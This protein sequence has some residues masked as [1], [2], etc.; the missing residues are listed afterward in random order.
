MTMKKT[1]LVFGLLS[2][3]LSALL[4][5]LTVPFMDRIG[6]DRGLVVGYTAMV[7]SFLFVYFGI[8][9]Y[10]DTVAGGQLSF[11][12]GVAVGLLITVVSC[13]CYVVAWQVL[14]YNFIPDFF[15]KYTAHAIEQLRASGASPAAIDQ[16]A[17]EMAD[18]KTMY[19]NPLVNA[20]FTFIEP[21]PVGLAITL[22]SAGLLRRT[23]ATAP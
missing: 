11:G 5:V 16:K 7:V 9:S 17:R 4:M 15:D 21:F 22:I 12:R 23:S 10:R 2:G 1:V 6:F 18:F 13:A 20:A 3:G 14:Y 19:D 8:R